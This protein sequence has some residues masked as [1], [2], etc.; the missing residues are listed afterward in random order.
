MKYTVS[1][2][3]SDTRDI[4]KVVLLTNVT[5][6]STNVDLFRRAIHCLLASG[7]IVASDPVE[8][9]RPSRSSLTS[10]I[11]KLP[12]MLYTALREKLNLDEQVT[13]T[14]TSP[15]VVATSVEEI[16]ASIN[17]DPSRLSSEHAKKKGANPYKV[18]DLK[19]I[20]SSLGLKA[21][22][23]KK[24]EVYTMIANFLR[25]RNLFK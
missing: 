3:L 21:S 17:F 2:F 5:I 16:L 25:D 24:H 9:V 10:G 13:T 8:Y 12:T 4:D 23:K 11:I 7:K 1:E 15:A 6:A 19:K 14:S 22:S 18:E 20:A